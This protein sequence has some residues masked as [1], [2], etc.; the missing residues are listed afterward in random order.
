[1]KT[2]RDDPG[3]FKDFIQYLQT[4]VQEKDEAEVASPRMKKQRAQ[5]P[6]QDSGTMGCKI[7]CDRPI[8]SVLV[9]CGHYFACMQCAERME[10]C[11]LCRQDVCFAQKTYSA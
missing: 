4:I 9:P 11:P 1:M 10:V 7:C 5:E 6:E 8:D 2:L 3:P